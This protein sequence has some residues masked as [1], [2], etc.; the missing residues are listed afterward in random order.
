VIRGN[1]GT[2][3]PTDGF[4][5]HVINNMDWGRDNLFEANVAKVNGS[6]YGFY[7]HPPETAI[8]AVMCNNQV[9]SADKGYAN[10]DCT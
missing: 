8:N 1:T 4:Q 6:G 2:N 9:S 3:S 5:T 10:V 7:I